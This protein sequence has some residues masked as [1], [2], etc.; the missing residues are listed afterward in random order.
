MIK[1]SINEKYESLYNSTPKFQD[2]TGEICKTLGISYDE[3]KQIIE[4]QVPTESLCVSNKC[5]PKYFEDETANW[6]TYRN[7]EYGFEI[8]YPSNWIVVYESIGK[9]VVF[10]A[11]EKE[12]ET[13]REKQAGE[14]RCSVELGV[15]NNEESLSLYDWAIDKWD[16]PEKRE[17]GKISEVK[18][19][20]LEGIKY[21]FMSMG[22]E[23]NVLFSKDNKVIDIQTTFDGCDN[24]HLLFN[25]ML[26]TFR[27]IEEIKE[28]AKVKEI[29]IISP[30]KREV[31]KCG[32]TYSITWTPS[33]PTGTVE[34]RL[35][36]L[37]EP[38]AALV[39]QW[40]KARIPNTGTYLFTVPK[41]PSSNV[42]QIH[43]IAEFANRYIGTREGYSGLFSIACE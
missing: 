26:S 22:T 19:N 14:I 42:Y 40:A 20:D 32:E 13:Q 6:K 39:N 34:I 24:L 12:A 37:D 27:F 43:I 35:N 21:E 31:W 4:G 10:F 9:E 41:L 1:I 30:L 25:Q 5:V 23:T 18:I 38:Y 3:Q 8:K 7:E 28:I 17:A 33:D 2:S 16:K 29:I 36:K 15:Y 11:D